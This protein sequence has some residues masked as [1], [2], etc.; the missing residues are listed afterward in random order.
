MRIFLYFIILTITSFAWAETSFDKAIDSLNEHELIKVDS[1]AVT[2]I[3]NDAT[4][5]GSWGDPRLSVAAVNYPQDSL[6]HD[7][8]MMTGVQLGIM[9]TISLS[10]KYDKLN[11]SVLEK[12]L[13]AKSDQLQT[14][15][16]LLKKLWELAIVQEKLRSEK[17]ILNENYKWLDTNLKVSKK[18]YTNGKI[19]QQAVLDIKLE[20]V[21][22]RSK[23]Q[24]K[25]TP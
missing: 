8:S 3:E 9:Q 18:L 24:K 10:G 23:L 2:A 19:P 13:A 20:K 12:S 5:A 7:E 16:N 6:A 21:N 11:D 4:A 25:T 17:A 14:R 15:R 1:L 22:W